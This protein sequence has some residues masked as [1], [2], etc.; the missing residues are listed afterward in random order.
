LKAVRFVIS[1]ALWAALSPTPHAHAETSTSERALASRLFD[2][3]SKL[4]AAGQTGVACAKYA[5]S[6]RIDPQL[7]TLLYLGECYAK[8]GKSASA[9]V[10]FKEAA[11]VAAQR[12]D[13][14][15]AKIRERLASIEKTLSNVVL[16]VAKDEPA[17]LE[18]RQDGALIG[19]AA[20]GSPIPIDPGEH[21]FSATAASAKPREMKASVASD[22]Q[23]V[24]V[25]LPPLELLPAAPAS[26][27]KSPEAAPLSA[28][29]PAPERRSWLAKRQKTVALV[30]AGVGVVSVGV[31]AAF[32]LMVKP[33]YDKSQADCNNDVCGASGHDYRESAFAKAMVSNVAFGVGAAALVGGAVLWLTAPKAP[34]NAQ[35]QRVL[36]APG[37][38]PSTA[39]I[40]VHRSW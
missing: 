8:V 9:W 7:G 39:M 32:G 4:M 38:G 16:V 37:I 40:S 12:G 14:R 33:T 31:G 27:E 17:D 1:L 36:I 18:I 13:P 6:K 15:T 35:A 5:E 2:E 10:S 21:L 3:A 22:G 30:T 29:A 23:T 34:E 20:W 19:R 26:P 24:T 11:D 25:E 28:N